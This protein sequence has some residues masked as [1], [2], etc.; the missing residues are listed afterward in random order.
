MLYANRM[1][2]S[3]KTRGGGLCVYINDAWCSNIVKAD[4][5]CFPDWKFLTLRC[6]PYYLPREFT[7]VFV[8]VVYILPDANV[9][10]CNT[11]TV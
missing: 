2:D 8:N 7:G 4:G 9:K 1:Q 3:S 6:R 11:G 5:Q 10:K